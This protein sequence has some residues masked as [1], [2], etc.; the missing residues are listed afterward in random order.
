MPTGASSHRQFQTASTRASLSGALHQGMLWI[1][2]LRV[3]GAGMFAMKNWHV[4][5]YNLFWD[6][7]RAN[8]DQAGRTLPLCDRQ[9]SHKNSAENPYLPVTCHAHCQILMPTRSALHPV[10]CWRSHLGALKSQD[11]TTRGVGRRTFRL[12]L[13]WPAFEVTAGC[14]SALG[15][16]IS[17]DIVAPGSNWA[18]DMA[19][20]IT[21]PNGNQ[22]ESRCVATMSTSGTRMLVAWPCGLELQLSDGNLHRDPSPGLDQFGLAGS[23]C[24][25]D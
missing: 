19:L 1:K 4:A 8:L 7:I 11:T 22:A 2:P 6:N 21:A 12:A 5:D 25:T 18:G 20:A 9:A 10:F 14:S 23:G 24:W 13:K 15:F 17:L 16:D 3:L